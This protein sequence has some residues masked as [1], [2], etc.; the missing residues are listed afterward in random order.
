[1][2][3]IWSAVAAA[4]VNLPGIAIPFDVVDGSNTWVLAEDLPDALVK[5]G[6]RPGWELVSVDGLPMED[7]VAVQRRVAEG[8]SRDVQLLFDTLAPGED[9]NVV[10]VAK[11]SPLVHVERVAVIPWPSDLKPASRWKE[12]WTGSPIVLDDKRA[13]WTFEVTDGQ[14][15]RVGTQDVEDRS[16]PPVFW[17]LTDANWVIDTGAAVSGGSRAWAQERFAKAARVGSFRGNVGDHLLVESDRGIQVFAI[18]YPQGTPRL[19]SCQPRVPETCLSSGLD[20]LANLET[21]AGAKAEAMRLFGLACANGVHRACYEAVALEE[22]DRA[23]DVRACLSRDVEACN[24]IARDRFEFDPV[25][26]DDVAFGLLEFACQLESSGSLG[27]RLQRIDDIGASC[28]LLA[29]AYD[30]RN[31]P[32][33]ALLNLDQACVLGRADACTQAANRRDQAYAARTVREC[34]DPEVPIAA[35]CVELGT[36]LDETSVPATEMDA[37]D[38]FLRGCS[39]GAID[40]CIALGEF[41]DRWGIEHPRV[42]AA[43]Q[44]LQGSCQTGEQRACVGAAHLLVRHEPR[45]TDYGRALTL[46]SSACDERLV[47]GCVA[48]AEQRRIGQAK[49][50]RAPD[51]VT[52]WTQACDLN[53]AEGCEGLGDRLVKIGAKFEP[54]F[55]AYNRSCELGRAHACSEIGQLVEEEK[56]DPL[57]GEQPAEVYLRRGCENGDPEGCYWLA[58]DELPRKGDP[59]EPVYVLLERSCEGDYGPGCERLAQVH[60]DRKTSFDNEIAAGHFDSACR[61]GFYDSCRTLGNMYRK[62]KGVEKDRQKARELLERFRLNERARHLRL[63]ATV[64]VP[65]GIAAE[66]E[67]LLPL[68]IGPGLAVNA[69]YSYLPFAGTALMA[70]QNEAIDATPDLTIYG[71]GG[72]FYPN[73]KGRGLYLGAGLHWF[74]ARGGLEGLTPNDTGRPIT[75]D[76]QKQEGETRTRS[77]FNAKVGIRSQAKATYSLVEIGLATYGALN[78]NHFDV[79]SENVVLP[80]ILPSVAFSFGF[81]VL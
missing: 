32:D 14:W 17:N 26:P 79:D 75:F 27:E 19:P 12:D 45:S 60:I 63:G 9:A 28:V 24:T 48:G 25:N 68:P 15:Y 29:K 43:E 31:A 2:W 61:N 65:Y 33:L 37:F 66:G 72:R 76:P 64:G 47:E 71:F 40:G 59:A 7:P 58:E 16:I 55:D 5:A 52:L 21:R 22:S 57:P 39:L 46:F 49:R 18:D 30:A 42:V 34:S 74:V 11:R 23:G 77:G 56:H 38:A 78:T 35:A 81:A 73:N 3:L 41:V 67:A 13:T 1:M 50:V 53:S 10:L 6:A 8:P 20:I 36:L 70:V 80:L 54:A 62:G 69:H 4:S 44:Q 51:Q